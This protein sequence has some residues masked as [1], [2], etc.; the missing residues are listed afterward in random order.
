MQAFA[1]VQEFIQALVP[2]LTQRNIVNPKSGQAA[3]TGGGGP[4][5]WVMEVNV[6][7]HCGPSEL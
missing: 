1:R 7:N 6:T 3:L 4:H 5:Q 2:T